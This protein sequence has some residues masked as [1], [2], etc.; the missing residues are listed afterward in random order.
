MRKERIEY[1]SPVD[2]LV[3]VAKRL[4]GY[5]I[6]C[7]LSSEEFFDG[8]P[9]GR[10]EDSPDFTNGQTITATI[11]PSDA[12]WRNTK[13]IQRPASSFS[14]SQAP[15]SGLTM[16]KLQFGV[17][18]RC[19]KPELPRLRS[20]AG[21]HGRQLKGSCCVTRNIDATIRHSGMF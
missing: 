21:A 5:E 4:S 14:R 8:Y 6:R 15:A 18:C 16:L 3:M 20:Q 10:M 12:T 19:W 2:A 1:D 9:N 17:T 13:R 11:W 7:R